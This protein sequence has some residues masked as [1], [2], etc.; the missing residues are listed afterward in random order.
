ME[1]KDAARLSSVLIVNDIVDASQRMYQKEMKTVNRILVFVSI[2]VFLLSGCAAPA[3][4]GVEVREAWARPAPQGGNGAIYFVIRSTEEDEIVGVSSDVA[5]AVEMHESR[6]S[7]DVM[8]MH[9]S[10]SVPLPAAEEVLFEPGGLHIMLIGLKQDL[11]AGDEFEIS[12]QFKNHQEVQLNIPVRETPVSEENHS[13]GSLTEMEQNKK[14]W[15]DQGISRYRYHLF[16]GCFCIFR[17]DMPLI[18]EVQD[19]Q[20]VSME[21]QSGNEIDAESREIF[22]RYETIDLIFS[23]LEAGLQGAADT[24]TVKYDPTYGF[25]IETTMDIVKETADDELSLT[26][27]NF[28][29]LP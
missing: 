22:K 29:V 7:G 4:E 6:M 23:E 14:K 27:S 18:I 28:E 11:K 2:I 17:D 24:V 9:Q 10:H 15:R 25:P 26:I 13:A 20:I 1:N 5:E 16:L 12:L 3:A 19:G 8:E 21:Y